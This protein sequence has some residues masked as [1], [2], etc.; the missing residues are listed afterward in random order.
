MPSADPTIGGNNSNT[1]KYLDYSGL[2]R[3]KDKIVSLLGGKQDT[4]VS[5][6]NIKTINNNS[7]LGNGN[8]SV[9]TI[10]GIKMN[11]SSKG[12]S[13]VVD[14]GTVITAHQSISGKQDKPTTL[15]SG[16]STSG[17]LT[18]S[19]SAS[20]YSY[21]DIQYRNRTNIYN[22]VRLYDPNGK[23]VNLT[24][25]NGEGSAGFYIYNTT[26]LSFNGTTVTRANNKYI[27]L[28][29]NNAPEVKTDT[30]YYT[31]TITKIVGYK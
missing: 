12:T 2:S 15:W 30:S 21:I 6:T 20:N 14:L 19:S 13:G 26:E 28:H 22:T 8:V 16:S 7:I 10:T 17:N 5:G 24:T 3:V 27:A 9:G 1:K 25:G 18:L 31:L 4:L 23:A 29:D 11:G